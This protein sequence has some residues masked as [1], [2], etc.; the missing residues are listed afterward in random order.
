MKITWYNNFV[1]KEVV[2]KQVYG[3]AF[4]KDGRILLRTYNLDGK[5]YFS[6]A[7][8]SPEDIDNGME[9]TLRREMLE[10]VNTT[11]KD[12]IEYI[13]YQLIDEEN[14]KVPYAQVR[15][16]ALIDKIGERREDPCTNKIYDR[17][18]ASPQR[19]IQLLDWKD[20]GEILINKAV[21]IAKEKF[22]LEFKEDAKEEWI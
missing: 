13:G 17:I 11:L 22:G 1:P 18:L 8:G 15:M 6:L 5:T 16:A 7:G 9:D 19:A 20:I 4:Y 12:K 10:E 3:V 14:G 21:D 2:V